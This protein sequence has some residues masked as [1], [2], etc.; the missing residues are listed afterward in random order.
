MKQNQKLCIK[1]KTVINREYWN[2][3]L[4]KVNPVK[5]IVICSFLEIS[6]SQ[7][8]VLLLHKLQD[9]EYE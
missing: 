8:A 5:N 7:K 6:L 4:S 3:A 2:K 9:H 1:K